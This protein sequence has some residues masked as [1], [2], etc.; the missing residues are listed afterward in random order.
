MV[1]LPVFWQLLLLSITAGL[2]NSV[3]HPADLS[4]LTTKISPKRLGKAYA[5]H[6]FS[7]NVGWALAPIF[8]VTI[9]SFWDWRAATMTAGVIGLIIVCIF[10]LSNDL[11][12]DGGIKDQK[13]NTIP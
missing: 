2:G 11:L 1:F 6:A 9:A 10:F 4:I 8:V 5:V 3:I 7:G 13:L 12:T